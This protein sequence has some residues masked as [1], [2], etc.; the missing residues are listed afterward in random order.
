MRPQ[1]APMILGSI[2]IFSMS[3]IYADQLIALDGLASHIEILDT[4]GCS[5]SIKSNGN[6][7]AIKKRLID[8]IIWGSDTISY[9][10]YIC[11]EKPKPAK[12][13]LAPDD[14]P[15]NKLIKIFDNAPKSDA[16]A[17]LDSAKIAF[18]IAPL[19]GSF[20]IEDFVAVMSPVYDYLQTIG[21]VIRITP[22]EL[23]KEINAPTGHFQYVFVPRIYR[24]SI[25]KPRGLMSLASHKTYGLSDGGY[26]AKKT[27]YTESIFLIYDLQKKEKCF[28]KNLL[29]KRTA[30]SVDES[31]FSEM[32]TQ[33]EL[34]AA[35]EK[36]SLESILDNNTEEIRDDIIKDLKKYLK[37]K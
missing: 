6:T 19:E 21:T 17:T 28:Q 3:S 35:W 2:M 13:V 8:Y 30:F 23:L 25:D 34:G 14:L 12:K 31:L 29:K 7:V 26:T 36:R 5:V 27:I 22:E 4:A 20:K 32:I 24:V 33:G 9:K 37:R 11:A 18:I 10:G 1:I 15:E 16:Y